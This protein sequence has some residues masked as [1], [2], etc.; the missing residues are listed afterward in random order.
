MISPSKFSRMTDE[1]QDLVLS[2]LL[3]QMMSDEVMTMMSIVASRNNNNIYVGLIYNLINKILKGNHPNEV[4]DDLIDKKV[5]N[6]AE[7]VE[8]VILRDNPIGLAAIQDQ[9]MD[10][11][12]SAFEKM[13][14]EYDEHSSV[15]SF[16]D[17][18]T[19]EESDSLFN[20]DN[21]YDPNEKLDNE[22]KDEDED[23]DDQFANLW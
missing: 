16:L 1:H 15:N 8:T 3:S 5:R 2:T 18:V 7:E 14:E 12:L 13:Q 4:L 10:D 11:I 17:F 19:S 20:E 22:E 23:D 9:D 21:E 6:V